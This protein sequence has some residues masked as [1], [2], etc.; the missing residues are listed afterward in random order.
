MTIAKNTVVQF[1]YTLREG[2][3]LIETSAGADPLAFLHGHGNIIPGL[4][5]AMEGKSKGD[6]FEVT[7]A[8]KD[9]YGERSD[10]ATQQVPIKHLQ[11]AKR[12]K[13]GMVAMIKTD[14]GM[15][16]VTIIK[17][18]LKHATV[19]VNHPLAGKELTFSVEIVDTRE[20]TDDEVAHGHA[21][22]V[23]GHHH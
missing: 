6:E 10:D 16:Q 11:G 22:G 1:H 23:G 12:W 14:K 4:E 5:K 3:E 9:A 8:C 20:A 19:D 15:R 17:A 13:P 21:H 18:G 2:D 7:V